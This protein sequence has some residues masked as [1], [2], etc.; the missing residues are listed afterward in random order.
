VP[1]RA[2]ISGGAGFLGLRL[3]CALVERGDDVTL[4]DDF[5][6]GRDDPALRELLRD[7]RLVEHDLTRPLPAQ[8]LGGDYGAVYHLAAVVGTQAS[9]ERPH[10]VLRVGLA[11]TLNLLDWAAAVQPERLFLSSTSEVTDGAV[12]ARLASVPVP[13]DV[14]LVVPDV[15]LPRASYAI[16]KIASEAQFL[17]YGN[18]HGALVRIGR[19]FNVYGPRMGHDHVIPQLIGRALDGPD[20]FPV[21]GAWQTRSFCFVD[22]AVEAALLLTE[23]PTREPVVASVGNDREEIVIADLVKRVLELAGHEAELEIHDPPRGSPARRCP[24]LCRLRELTG[25]EPR[26]GL[27]DGLRQTVEWYRRHY[28]HEPHRAGAGGR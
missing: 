1:E 3:A 2:L 16:S 8:Q 21:Y 6:R 14:P 27:D 22:D 18:E 19:F 11:A 23:L 10:E 12:G 24:D 9:A 5:S 26:V 17:H 7:A 15:A 25:Y 28:E 20:P 4:L 13:D